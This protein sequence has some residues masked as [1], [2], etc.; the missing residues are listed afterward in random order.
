[1]TRTAVASNA[2]GS[3]ATPREATAPTIV[4]GTR[5]THSVASR[6][7]PDDVRNVDTPAM[8][9]PNASRRTPSRNVIQARPRAIAP[10]PPWCGKLESAQYSTRFPT[11]IRPSPTIAAPNATRPTR[12]IVDRQA[13]DSPKTPR[14]IPSNA[15]VHSRLRTTSP[16]GGQNANTVQSAPPKSPARPSPSRTG[17][18]SSPAEL[19]TRE[20]P[21]VRQR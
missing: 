21:P 8:S 5:S 11:V 7:E 9:D 3:A 20:Q 15:G 18:V 1:M 19:A 13:S 16:S 6:C 14:H 17:A 2:S 4:A 12:P 10:N